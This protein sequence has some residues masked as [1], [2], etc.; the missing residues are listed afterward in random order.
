MNCRLT[1]R[2]DSL[3]CFRNNTESPSERCSQR[4]ST[5]HSNARTDDERP[6]RLP[7]QQSVHT[8]LVVSADSQAAEMHDDAT[9]STAFLLPTAYRHQKLSFARTMA[10]LTTQRRLARQ[11]GASY[12]S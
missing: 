9:A 5:S 12:A 11:E 4:S 2:T 8:R 6:R 10:R 7:L 3:C 1:T